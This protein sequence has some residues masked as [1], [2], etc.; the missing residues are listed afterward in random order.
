MHV[1]LLM[2]TNSKTQMVIENERKWLPR[3]CHLLPRKGNGH[4]QTI[5]LRLFCFSLVGTKLNELL[6]AL[7]L[8]LTW[9]TDTEAFHEYEEKD[10]RGI[11]KNWGTGRPVFTSNQCSNYGRIWTSVSFPLQLDN[12]VSD[13]NKPLFHSDATVTR[14]PDK[15]ARRRY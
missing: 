8:K 10:V 15:Q 14:A 4:G 7:T 13:K 6:M 12:S 5:K 9:T 2:L 1:F 3:N 11:K